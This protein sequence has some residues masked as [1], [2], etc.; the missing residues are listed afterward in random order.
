M[1]TA[2]EVHQFWFQELS[3]KDHFAKSD[4]IDSEIRRRFLPTMKLAAKGELHA[5][6]A[7]AAGRLSE[8]IVLDQ[9]SRNV[10]RERAEA[11]AQDPLALALAQEAVNLGADREASLD[12]RRFFYMPFMHSE[13]RAA[14]EDAVR[15]FSQPGLEDNLKFEHL[16]KRIID[17]F[18]RFPHRNKVLGRESTREEIEFLKTAN[19]A[20]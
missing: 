13:S 17:Q 10:Y 3:K 11:F 15:L 5:W 6:R 14:H 18:G 16:H 4:P 19:S 1:G 7:T 20:F 12:E 9:F 8:I 2:S